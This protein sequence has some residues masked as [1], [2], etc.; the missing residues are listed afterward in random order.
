[1]KPALKPRI[2]DEA[3]SVGHILFEGL[4]GILR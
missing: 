1:M 3:L 4:F 2:R